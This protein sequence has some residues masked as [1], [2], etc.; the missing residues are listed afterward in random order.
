[1]GDTVEGWRDLDVPGAVCELKL[2]GQSVGT[3]RGEDVNGHP[4]EP[5]IW[6]ANAVASRG[7]SLRKGDVVITG[8][9]IPPIFIESGTLAV[10]EMDN[11]GT[12][13]LDVV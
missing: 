4:V 3:A 10:V 1:M 13:S 5:M 7:K 12:V 2:N 8:S 9:M 6:I 11:L